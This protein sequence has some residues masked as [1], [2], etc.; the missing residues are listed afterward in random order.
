MMRL[1]LGM[2]I[3]VIVFNGCTYYRTTPGYTPTSKFDR[4]WAAAISALEDQGVS[5]TKKDRSTGVIKGNRNGI[6]VT[7]NIQTQA[8][9]SVR[10][11]FNTSGATSRD[12]EL[13]NRINSSYDRR[14]GR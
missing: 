10:V 4:S 13:I 12:P 6:D 11:A 3:A 1:L 5:I 7:V 14:M 9:G 2:I 8:D